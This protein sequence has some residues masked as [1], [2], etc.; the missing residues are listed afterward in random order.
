MIVRGR[1]LKSFLLIF[2]LSIFFSYG[3]SKD[4]CSKEFSELKGQIHIIPNRSALVRNQESIR[5]DIQMTKA[6]TDKPEEGVGAYK[7][8]LFEEISDYFSHAQLQQHKVFQTRMVRALNFRNIHYIGELVQIIRRD[9]LDIQG[10]SSESI[11]FIEEALSERGLFFGVEIDEETQKVLS[12]IKQP[13]DSLGF[14]AR[15]TSLLKTNG[16]YTLRDLM[17][18]T[19][20]EL[21]DMPSI[22]EQSVN[23]MEVELVVRGL[24]LKKQPIFMSQ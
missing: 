8:L 18:K 12:E 9:L 1:S 7:Y 10:I 20:A 15:L 24:S 11:D 4:K 3:E 19:R 6:H 5:Q 14:S 23:K 13:L 16:I 21:L 17:K 22:E 2:V